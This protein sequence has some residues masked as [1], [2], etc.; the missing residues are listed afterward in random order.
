MDETKGSPQ[1]G[2]P[3]GCPRCDIDGLTEQSARLARWQGWR[4]MAIYA[5]VFLWPLALAVIGA[6]LLPRFWKHSLSQVTGGVG[7]LL[8]GVIDAAAVFGFVFKGTPRTQ[9]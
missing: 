7:G 4:L 5:L 3:I 1:A 9:E 2:C 6:L 8:L